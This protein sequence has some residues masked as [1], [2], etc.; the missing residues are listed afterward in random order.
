MSIVR[1]YLVDES[2]NI[3]S[4]LIDYDLYKKIEPIL[5]DFALGVAMKEVK[6]EEQIDLTSAIKMI[7]LE[8]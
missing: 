4:V 8:R 7:N 5:L 2:G 3:K 6:N 1:D